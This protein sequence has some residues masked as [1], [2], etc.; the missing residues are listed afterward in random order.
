MERVIGSTKKHFKRL[1]TRLKLLKDRILGETYTMYYLEKM[2]NL[3]L[4]LISV[5]TL[6]IQNLLFRTKKIELISLTIAE[7]RL[8]HRLILL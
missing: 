4:R 2:D 6:G 1:T 5:K 7:H 3:L 8:L